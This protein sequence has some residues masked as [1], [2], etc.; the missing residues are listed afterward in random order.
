ME[1]LAKEML[2]YLDNSEDVKVG[3]KNG[4]R[5]LYKL[6]LLCSKWFSRRG[7][8]LVKRFLKSS[9]KKKKRYV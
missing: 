1:N 6:V 8:K 3:I 7:M 5:Y 4:W 9:G 2:R